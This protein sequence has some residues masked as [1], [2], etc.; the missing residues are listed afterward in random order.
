MFCGICGAGFHS[1]GVVT[2]RDLYGRRRRVILCA[3]CVT[4]VRWRQTPVGPVRLDD[5]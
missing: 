3:F 5:V 1:G 4:F 2:I